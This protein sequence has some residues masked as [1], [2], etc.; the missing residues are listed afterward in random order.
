MLNK[1]LSSFTIACFAYFFLLI[2][3]QKKE[4]KQVPR[5]VYDQPIFAEVAT[6]AVENEELF[7]QFKRNPFFNLHWENL[8]P[9]EG[10][11]WLKK[12]Q[13]NYPL[14]VEKLNCFRKIDAIGSPRT[15]LFKEAGWF[16]PSTLRLVAIAGD[17]QQKMGDLSS[18][19]IVQ[20]GAG[21]GEL[22]KIL[23]E[24]SSF[25]SYTLV[26]LPEQLTLA[27]K[28]LEK[29]GVDNV[30][31]LTPEELPDKAS[32]DCV[33][34]DLSFSEFNRS[35]QALFFDKILSG[36]HSGYLLGRVFPKHFGVVAWNV[37]ELNARFEKTGKFSIWEMQ[38]PTIERESYFVFWKK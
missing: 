35:Y 19:H 25:K 16:S 34:S 26:D 7:S 21:C 24:L 27:K 32:Y 3:C 14:L 9:Q 36:S 4:D 22:C 17:L 5:C 30:C 20:I 38:E 12:I 11:V 29:W 13:S 37:D 10:E 31:F 2:G 28:C 6:K 33:I 18:L 23:H 15:Y 8:T 1:N